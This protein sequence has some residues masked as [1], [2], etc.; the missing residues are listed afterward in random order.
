[1][2]DFNL[3]LISTKELKDNEIEEKE[4]D[5]KRT[6]LEIERERAEK[7]KIVQRRGGWNINK[8]IMREIGY[9]TYI[10]NFTL[11]LFI[12]LPLYAIKYFRFNFAENSLFW[13]K[14]I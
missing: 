9:Y 14:K 5:L 3:R 11:I 8:D 6:D 10:C 12:Y 4:T 1:M 7:K 13:R 2:I